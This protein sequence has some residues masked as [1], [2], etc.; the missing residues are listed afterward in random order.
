VD[1]DDDEFQAKNTTSQR[2]QSILNK[3]F[4]YHHNQSKLEQLRDFDRPEPL[5]CRAN[6]KGERK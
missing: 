1:E 2:C 3:I 5:S 4:S 6:L